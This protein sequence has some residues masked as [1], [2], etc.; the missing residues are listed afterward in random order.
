LLFPLG[1][2]LGVRRACDGME[3]CGL[4]GMRVCGFA[5]RTLSTVIVP[6]PDAWLVRGYEGLP[7]QP[8]PL[9]LSHAD[10]RLPA[11][12]K[13]GPALAYSKSDSSIG[14]ESANSNV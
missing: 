10:A 3:M 9:I 11:P 5:G 4:A 7:E 6:H 2:P 1:P 14:P 12:A 8:H 13:V